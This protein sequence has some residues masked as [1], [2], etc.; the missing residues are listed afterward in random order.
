MSDMGTAPSGI[1]ILM[2]HAIAGSSTASFRPYTVDP[3]LFDEHIA[4]LLDA[5]CRFLTVEEVPALLGRGGTAADGK[6]AV[7]VSID[8]ALADEATAVLAGRGVPATLFVPTAYVGGTA[9]W[10]SGADS[11]LPLLGWGALRELAS[12]GLEIAAHGHLH[13]AADINEPELVREDAARSRDELESHLERAVASYAYPFGCWTPAARR[14]V[15]AAGF[16]QACAIMDLPAI[17]SDDRFALPRLYVGPETTPEELLKLV[18]SRPI[19]LARRRAELGQR[20]WRSGRRWAGWGP[21]ETSVRGRRSDVEP[22]L[23]S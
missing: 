16:A 6:T 4:A 5:R 2:Y 19:G 3:L 17:A 20:I 21:P 12:S 8:D 23:R 18:N 22:S 15:R 7:V 13:L 1:A 11:E 14:A 10:L 9:R